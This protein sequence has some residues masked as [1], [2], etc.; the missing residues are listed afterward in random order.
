MTGMETTK[1]DALLN[2]NRK[3]ERSAQLLLGP[4][5]IAQIDRPRSIF[6]VNLQ[7]RSSKP[8]FQVDLP[9]RS[10]KSICQVDLRAV[11]DI[12]RAGMHPGGT[13]KS[14]GVTERR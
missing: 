6:N 4:G 14:Q 10:A 2:V 3:T 8:I 12:S 7:R 11:Y 5:Q 9:S 13:R 1:P